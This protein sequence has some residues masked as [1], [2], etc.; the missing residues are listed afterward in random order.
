M[1]ITDMFTK[2]LI[3]AC[4]S[5][6]WLQVAH[7]IK[8]TYDMKPFEIADINPRRRIRRLLEVIVQSVTDYDDDGLTLQYKLIS[9]D[10]IVLKNSNIKIVDKIVP[11]EYVRLLMLVYYYSFYLH[12][13]PQ[14]YNYKLMEIYDSKEEI[15]LYYDKLYSELDEYD[16]KIFEDRFKLGASQ[17]NHYTDFGNIISF[18]DKKDIYQKNIVIFNRNRVP[19]N[20]TFIIGMIIGVVIMLIYNMVVA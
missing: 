17:L 1:E 13:I 18:I 7:S 3:S 10:Y 5:H 14:K 2:K 4:W 11:I 12:K 6:Y 20:I 19:T 15:D 8:F 9:N 16:R